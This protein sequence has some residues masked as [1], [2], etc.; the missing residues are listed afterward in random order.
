MAPVEPPPPASPSPASPPSSPVSAPALEAKR[1]K[2]KD[3]F[4]LGFIIGITL[5][6]A[7]PFLQRRFLKAPPPIRSL[8][9]WQLTSIAD[10][11]ALSSASLAGKV[12]LMELAASPCEA[13][14]IERQAAFSTATQHTDDFGD[15]VHLV[16]VVQS[17]AEGALLAASSLRPSQRW[18]LASGDP[19]ALLGG[20]R[21]GWLLW[22][23]TDAGQSDEEFFQLPAVIL[24]DQEGQ[25]RG[26]WRDD[27]TGRGNAINAARLLA[28]HGPRP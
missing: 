27:P 25:L 8:P 20:L 9:A 22:A 14:C 1:P 17:G 23:K 19:R 10:G 11:G 16:T 3:P 21:D 28:E 6:T 2:W 12:L 26:F 5:L 18:H 7:L 4:V 24:V 15:K 13:A